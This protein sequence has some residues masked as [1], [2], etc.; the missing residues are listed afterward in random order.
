MR[1]HFLPMIAALALA[2]TPASALTL[3]QAQAEIAGYYCAGSTCTKAGGT[4]TERIGAHKGHSPD[5]NGTQYGFT[6]S[7]GHWVPG[8]SVGSEDSGASCTAIA[9]TIV[10][11]LIY[12]GPNTDRANA[13]SVNTSSLSS[14]SSC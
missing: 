9:T 6:H 7:L 5:F 4:T 3:Q 14:K 11:E 10:K 8:S 13:W 12:N 2:A 1:L